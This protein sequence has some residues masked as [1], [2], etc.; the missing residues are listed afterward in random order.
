MELRFHYDVVCPWAYLASTQIEAAAARIGARLS[1]SPVLLGGVLRGVGAPD[2]PNV[3]MSAARAAVGAQDLLRFADWLG[4]PLRPPAAH[5]RRTV[6]AMRLCLLAPEGPPRVA[7]TK[8][9]FRAYW[10]DGRDVADDEVLADIARAHA[11]DPAAIG[12]EAS[13]AALHEATAEAVARGVFGVPTFTCGDVLAFG[14]DRLPQLLARLGAGEEPR[15][16]APESPV[17]RTRVAFFH[18]FSSPFSYLAATQIDALAAEHGVELEHVPILLG[19]LFRQ[20]GTPDVPLFAMNGAKRAWVETD[21]RAWADTWR[22]PFSFPRHFPIRSVL[23]LRVAIVEPRATAAIYRAAWAEDRRIDEP[24]ALGDVLEEAGFEAGDLLA[25]AEAPATKQALFHN[26]E[27]AR[28]AGVCGVPTFRIDR[29]DRQI[30]VWG[31]DRLP[32]LRAVLSGW[33]PPRG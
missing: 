32:M 31:Q 24:S 30:L 17:A 3:H 13:K 27:R 33:W 15:L 12:S 28:T 20:I 25:Q 14:V 2:D 22:V 11:I 8:A 10:V 5:P 9:L 6:N 26:T 16:G 4:V 23:P 18:D 7:V 21:L 1:W 19:A 29:E